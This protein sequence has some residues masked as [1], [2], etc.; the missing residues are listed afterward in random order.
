M[1]GEEGRPSS[2]THIMCLTNKKR[3]Y[4]IKFFLSHPHQKDTSAEPVSC[5]LPVSIY[6]LLKTKLEEWLLEKS[7]LAL[8]RVLAGLWWDIISAAWADP[9]CLLISVLHYHSRDSIPSAGKHRGVQQT[10]R[11]AP[12]VLRCKR[13]SAVRFVQPGA[14]IS[15]RKQVPLKSFWHQTCY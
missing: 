11:Q 2:L 1:A 8:P 4:Y 3:H 9:A 5:C 15:L 12:L 10:E 14:K 13:R 7:I 6:L